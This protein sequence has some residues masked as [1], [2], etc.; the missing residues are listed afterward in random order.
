MLVRAPPVLAVCLGGFGWKKT[1]FR[2]GAD[3]GN[4]A[5]SMTMDVISMAIKIISL[6]KDA[7]SL[8]IKMISMVKE[9]I[10]LTIKMVFMTKAAAPMTIKMAALPKEIVSMTI[11]ILFMTKELSEMVKEIPSMVREMTPVSNGFGH[12][13]PFDWQ[14]EPGRADAKKQKP[15]RVIRRKTANLSNKMTLFSEGEK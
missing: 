1:A 8:T 9:I 11:K 13:C 6:T 7:I 3:G 2:R 15:I 14:E 12:K 4:L 10:S 5:V